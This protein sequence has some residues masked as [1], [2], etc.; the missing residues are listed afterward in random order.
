MNYNYHNH[1]K[2]CGHAW[3]EVEE[4]IQRAIEG[5]IKYMGFSDHSPFKFPDGY[6]SDFRVPVAEATDYVNE[7]KELREKMYN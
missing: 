2:R 1:T 5:K 6:E 3:G 7:I 4:Y